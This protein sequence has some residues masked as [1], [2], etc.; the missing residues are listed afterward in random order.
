MDGGDFNEQMQTT[1]E[2]ALL[3]INEQRYNDL[4]LIMQKRTQLL[5]NDADLFHEWSD[6]Q[7]NVM[8]VQTQNL[9][10]LIDLK[11]SEIKH[12]LYSIITTAHVHRAYAQFSRG[13]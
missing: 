13:G 6:I 2:D 11:I 5:Q 4:F 7:I 9:Q 8:K 1:Y 10:D 3:A 12:H